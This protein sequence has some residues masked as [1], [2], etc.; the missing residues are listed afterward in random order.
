MLAAVGEAGQQD[1][2][3]VAEVPDWDRL[4]FSEAATLSLPRIG[5]DGAYPGTV[6]FESLESQVQRL[7]AYVLAEV[8]GEPSQSQG[9]VDTIIRLH[10]E[11]TALNS[12]QAAIIAFMRRRLKQQ[13]AT[14]EMQA[15]LIDRMAPSIDSP[16]IKPDRD[17]VW[18]RVGGS[19]VPS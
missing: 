7:A 1:L 3:A 4:K 16:T 14:I 2:P 11:L 15:G 8:P 19:S 6:P 9:A 10:R 5:L 17:V 13:S 12:S 18:D